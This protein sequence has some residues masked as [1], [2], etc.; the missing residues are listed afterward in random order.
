MSCVCF[1]LPHIS[2]QSNW[3]WNPFKLGLSILF[4]LWGF[5]TLTWRLACL[6]ILVWF[7]RCYLPSRLFRNFTFN[8]RKKAREKPWKGRTYYNLADG[9]TASAQLHA[10][11][12]PYGNFFPSLNLIAN[13][14]ISWLALLSSHLLYLDWGK[15]DYIYKQSS[16]HI[17]CNKRMVAK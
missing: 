17:T 16:L 13:G 1:L 12:F 11:Y 7:L 6:Q 2:L 3:A 15:Y 14:F 5:S 9:V 10:L 4:S 8:Y